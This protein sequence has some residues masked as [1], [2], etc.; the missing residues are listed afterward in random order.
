MN[1]LIKYI[2]IINLSFILAAGAAAQTGTGSIVGRISD[3]NGEPMVGAT[4]L[5]EPLSLGT[6][7]DA[8]G[9]YQLL[10]VPAGTHPVKISFIGYT[11]EEVSV[12]VTR[13]QVY[14][15]DRQMSVSAMEILEVTAYGQARGQIAAINQQL[16]AKGITNVVSGEKLQELPDVNVAEAIGRLP[17]L[18]VERNRGE[19]QKIIIRGLAPK[20][21]TISVGGHMA[22]STS[23]DDRSTDLNMISPDILGGVEVQKA[24]TADRDADGLGGTVNLTLREAPAGLK[25]N[26]DGLAGY[27]GHSGKI[28][29]FK[30]SLHASNRFF[31]DR[32]GIMVTGNIEQA[33]R[34]S[35][36]FSVSYSVSGIPDYDAGE[37]YIKPWI[38]NAEVQANIE[39]RTRAGGSLLMDWKVH[40]SS[41]IKLSN[42][43]GYL[44]R[45]IFDRTKNYN[46]GSNYINIRAYDEDISQLLFTNAIDGKHFLLSSVLEWGVS[47]SQSINDKP[48]GH[49]ADFRQQSAYNNYIM[50]ESF[51]VEPPELVPAPENLKESINQYYFYQSRNSTYDAGESETSFFVNWQTPFRAGWFSGFVKAGAKH[52]YKHRDRTNNV[53][54]RRIDYPD[55]VNDFLQVYPDYT[56]TTEGNIGKIQMLNFMDTGYEPREFMRGK[57]QYLRVNEVLDSDKLKEVYANYLED[58]E[59]YIGSGAKDDYIT[60]ESI[61]AYYL[62]S[63]LNF[64]KYIS[65]IPGL[66]MERTWLEYTAYISDGVTDNED[67]DVTVIYKDTTASNSYYDLL[68]QIHLRIK[69]TSWFDIR[70]AYTNTLSR[71]DY[72]QLA[73]KEL[74]NVTSQEVTLGNTEL[75]PA[76]SENFDI[77]LTFYNQRFG[78]LTLGAFQK[79]IEGFIWNRTA[80]IRANT[81]TDPELLKLA[82]STLGYTVFYP[83]NNENRSTIRGLEFD[84]QSNLDFLP[85]KGIVFNANFTLMTSE[86]GYSETLIER[87]LNP[88][89]GVVPGAP[90]VIL[91]NRDTVY[92]DRLLSQ[93][94]YLANLGLGY[95]NDRIGLS[96]RLSLNF[97]DDILIR[98]QRRPDG[99]DREATLEFLRWDFQMNQRITKSISLNANVSNI[100][101]RPDHS[102]RLIT[103]YIRELEYYGLVAQIGL[104]YNFNSISRMSH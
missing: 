67:R 75:R 78:L 48:Y 26:F 27:S 72:N 34:N 9:N 13:G 84:L 85:L 31:G 3:E 16:N 11:P 2:S 53:T 12:T 61:R 40:P 23:P 81:D 73:P 28:S 99:A 18:M 20:Y 15:L 1:F 92:F 64:G 93:P 104:R 98:E 8:N 77:I 79:N 52:R 41:T 102:V 45:S 94:N 86:T 71:A 91:A 87:Q 97:Q 69:P 80:L 65:F 32:L 58:W 60:D 6:I 74:I 24:N 44:D 68:P 103:G 51:D 83:L 47:R 19:G 14:R 46:L 90:R 30:G 38:S 54:G 49:R 5:I 59:Y 88:D 100:F 10:G 76:E 29:N 96:V 39:N 22:P 37:T 101:N 33:E 36:N 43:V 50:G 95:D 35:D 62:M 7:A 70:L 56:L 57:Y 63:E 82:Q 17:G 25:F 66:R 42:F 4:I 89:F 21:N 55:E